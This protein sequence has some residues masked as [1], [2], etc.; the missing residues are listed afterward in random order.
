MPVAVILVHY[1]GVVEIIAFA[2]QL[3]VIATCIVIGVIF[4][5]QHL[6]GLDT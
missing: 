3:V 2:V 4:S 6:G 1:V 5:L